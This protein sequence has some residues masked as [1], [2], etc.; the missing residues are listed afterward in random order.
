[1]QDEGLM[2]DWL[3]P[4]GLRAL[5]WW[6]VSTVDALPFGGKK[7]EVQTFGVNSAAIGH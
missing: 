3:S 1:M 5:Q 2:L 4:R 7:N 6:V